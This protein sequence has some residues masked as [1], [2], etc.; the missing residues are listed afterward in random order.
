MVNFGKLQIAHP[1]ALPFQNLLLNKVCSD[2]TEAHSTTE[3]QVF[4]S[5]RWT[6]KSN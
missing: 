1:Q 5:N 6:S 4:P 2:S 3:F